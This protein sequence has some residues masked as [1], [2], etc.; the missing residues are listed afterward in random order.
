MKIALRKLVMRAR[1]G[2]VA[3]PFTIDHSPFTGSIAA[4]GLVLWAAAAAAQDV[5]F[6]QFFEAP[7]CFP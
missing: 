3:K 1:I 5:H 6:S 2:F 4:L 7:L